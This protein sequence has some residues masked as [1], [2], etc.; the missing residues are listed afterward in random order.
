MQKFALGYDFHVYD[1][2]LH[3]KEVQNKCEFYSNIEELL[4]DYRN[5][6]ASTFMGCVKT[7]DNFK[8]YKV[9][10]EELDIKSVDALM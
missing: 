2:N 10:L 3:E 4:A 1:I 5:K 9:H 6:K 7:H 8:I